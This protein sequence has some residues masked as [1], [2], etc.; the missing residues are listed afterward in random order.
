[1]ETFLS[2]ERFYKHTPQTT[3]IRRRNR[4]KLT[5]KDRMKSLQK[6]MYRRNPKG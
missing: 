5:G 3:T 6:R 4:K 1:M 2:F